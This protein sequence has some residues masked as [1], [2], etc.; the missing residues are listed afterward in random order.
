[1]M[2]PSDRPP[3]GASDKLWS[4]KIRISGEVD[5]GGMSYVLKG[6]DTKLNRELAL[7]VSPAP[8]NQLPTEQLARFI[9]EAQI[10]A[11]LEHPNV[12]PV[13]EIGLDPEG[14]VYFS[15][16]LVRG[17][18]LESILQ[19]RRE[20]DA[21]TLAEF[22]LRKLLDVFLH[23]CQAI[24]YAHARG[25]IHRDI[26]PANI[27]VGGFGEVL[28]MDWGIAKVAG[29]VEHTGIEGVTVEP[30]Y[31]EKGSIPPPPAD[32]S[33]IRSGKAHLATKMGELIGTPV[34][35][36]PE[37]AAGAVVD[38]S[39]D[40]Y[41]LGVILYE[42]L[43]GELPFNDADT[44]VLLSKILS[45][46]P[47]SPSELN[48][49]TPPALEALALRLLEKDRERRLS[50]PEIRDHIQNY[51][52]GI[53]RDYRRESL[54]S[55]VLWVVGGVALFAFLVWYVTG[56]SIT[57][58][59]V[60]APT[61][62][63][64]SLG[65]YLVVL[66][67]Q[68][69]LWA[70]WVSLKRSRA[71]PDPF[72]PASSS[73][74]FV[75]GYLAHRTLATAIAP[76]FQLFFIV[77]LL[78][79]TVAQVSRGAALSS[80]MMDRMMNELRAEW[81]RAL[82]VILL[83]LFGYLFLL[84]R[85]VRFAR[86]LDRYETLVRRSKWEA[87]WPIFLIAILL[88]TIVLTDVLGSLVVTGVRPGAYIRHVVTQPISVLEVA[89][90]F[91]LQGTFLLGLVFT[92]V[93]LA[94]PFPEL[95]AA[96]RLPYQPADQAAVR[97]RAQ[98]FLRSLAVFRVTRVNWLYGG[99]MMGCL[100]ALVGLSGNSES[101]L[102]QRTLAVLGPSL[103]GFVGYLLTRRQLTRLLRDSPAVAR[104]LDRQASLGR[105]ERLEARVEQI[106][107]APIRWRLI[108][109]LVPF[110]CIAGLL[111]ITGSGFHQ[112]AIGQLILPGTFEGWLLILPYVLLVPM[113]LAGDFLL[114]RRA[115]SKLP[116]SRRGVPLRE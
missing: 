20:G 85:Q 91:V 107:Q 59:F 75:L 83:F 111:V 52:E 63:F 1:M 68:Y 53:E 2:N 103:I 4:R 22:G 15:M 14:R 94:F 81:G 112:R 109:L 47:K 113:I 92:M 16:K 34:Y 32:V 88:G 77:E 40:V 76:L 38:E 19:S 65:W 67:A 6:T 102:L 31:T 5:R 48:P 70:S 10:T 24:E 36:S 8:R 9:E 99:A 12:V 54:W 101:P 21:D 41:A 61:T 7:K 64:N 105:L 45:V 50:I 13:H 82:I 3:P 25:V 56:Q 17:R 23:A 46:N 26:K 30:S 97:G 33:S 73:D 58:L 27:M 93:L 49:A 29:G 37:Q 62:V 71:E 57:A 44:R 60:L 90:T 104:L 95:L 11:Q 79:M 72:L 87:V 69:P 80:N 51:I 78:G 74:Q 35:M 98:Y 108:S 86:R 18:S 39:A 115:R 114:M 116:H 42:I 96:L 89:K 43:C 84:S 28:V 55:N 100:T 106:S 66:G 110:A